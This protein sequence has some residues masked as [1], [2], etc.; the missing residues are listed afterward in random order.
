MYQLYF[1]LTCRCVLYDVLSISEEVQCYRH[2]CQ[3]KMSAS[4]NSE[5]CKAL[6]PL[7]VHR[8]KENVSV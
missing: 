3:Y 8:G 4:L 6:A 2:T 5:G 7:A 1:C